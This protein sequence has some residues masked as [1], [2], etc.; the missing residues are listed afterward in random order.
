MTLWAVFAAMAL[1]A[2]AALA[3]PLLVRRAPPRPRAA[4][5]LE[6]YRDQLLEVAR[7]RDG[8]LI[9]EGEAEA[10]EAEIGR[11]LLAAE[12]AL[13]G[14]EA[15]PPAARRPGL[16][17]VLGL[18]VP[19]LAAAVYGS[20]GAPG[21]PAGP[22]AE[23][24]AA[25]ADD[26][27]ALAAAVYGSLGAPGLPAG[28]AAER[29][30]ATADDLPALAARLAARLEA[31]PGDPRG[32]RLLGRVLSGLERF[33]EAARAYG[34]AAA[35]LP[36][37]AGLRA[38]RGEALAAADGGRVTEAARRAFADALAR[39]AGEPRAR[40]Y[41]G[42]A[43]LQAGD[44]EAALA[45]WRALAADSGPDSPW[46]PALRRRID[47]VAGAAPPQAGPDAADV[48]AA[49]LLSAEDRAAM[50]RS[51]VESLARRLEEDPD[52]AEGWARLARSY[53]VLGEADKARGALARL[54][55]LR[56]GDTDVLLAYARSLAEGGPD[57]ARAAELE[58]VIG[59][60]LALDPGNRA[61]LRIAGEAA[62]RQAAPAE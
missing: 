7:A 16:A 13:R 54:T 62:D 41:L 4:H 33:D 18:A 14:G 9:P 39:D 15:A 12:D 32:W 22:A 52:D 28:P 5:D 1:G 37:D 30:A 59:R 10:A 26:L 47:A 46:L 57:G 44:R 50:I 42:L 20:L 24:A 6:I 31:G 2:S 55:R 8:G 11:R 34:R 29:A 48:A 51:M 27:P 38:L 40:F 36:G 49:A 43:A 58:A 17:L 3:A 45:R 60:I 35:L 25:T 53:R 61:A 19:A 56:P 23:R 21:L